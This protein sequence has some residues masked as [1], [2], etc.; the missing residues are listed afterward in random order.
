MGTRV[1]LAPGSPLARG[2]HWHQDPIGTRIPS[3][4]GS[5]WH[6]GPIG[7]RIPLAPGSPW[8]EG[9]IGTRVPLARGS[10][11][12]K[13][14]QAQGSPRLRDQLG[15]RIPVGG[16][17]FD[18]GVPLGPPGV[19]L[20]PMFSTSR[21]TLTWIPDSFFSS[22]LS[23]RISTLK[24]ETGAIFI[25]RDPTVFAP[26]LNFLRTKELD[27]SGRRARG[28]ASRAPCASCAATTTGSPW[29]TRSSWCA[30]GSGAL[31]R[32]PGAPA[33]RFLAR[34]PAG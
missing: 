17:S 24:D 34:V 20:A 15:T 8:H 28:P 13:S 30:T 29:P 1:P 4:P 9:P 23:G 6:E 22:L 16:G 19:P 26:I 18:P 2:S 11:C 32:A 5:P 12:H 7:T 27:A 3:A 10:R 31:R 21:Q 14:P 25:D 33:R